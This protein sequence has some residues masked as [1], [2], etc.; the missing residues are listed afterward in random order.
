MAPATRV[1]RGR[2][3]SRVVMADMATNYLIS[4]SHCVNRA[5]HD[6]LQHALDSKTIIEQAKGI[7]ANEHDTTVDPAFIRILPHARNH[8]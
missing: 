3:R 2:H 1:A 4:A 5:A 6:Q 8:T 7:V